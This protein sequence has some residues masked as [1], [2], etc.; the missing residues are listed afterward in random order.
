MTDSADKYAGGEVTRVNS[1][2]Y[3]VR[4]GGWAKGYKYLASLSKWGSYVCGGV[5]TFSKVVQ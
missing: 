3:I 1:R 5:F 2:V 4:V